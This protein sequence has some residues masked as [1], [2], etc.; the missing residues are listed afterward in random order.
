MLAR[1]WPRLA[2]AAHA[3]LWLIMA[4]HACPCVPMAVTMPAHGWPWLTMLAYGLSWPTMA[5]YACPWLAMA[6][7]ESIAMTER[8]R[9]PRNVML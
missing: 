8:E 4:D 9:E 6:D 7:L 3:C 5:D 2:M 1:G